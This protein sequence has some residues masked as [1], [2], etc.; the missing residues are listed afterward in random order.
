M[1]KDTGRVNIQDQSTSQNNS[2]IAICTSK[3]QV[4]TPSDS[5]DPAHFT[6]PKIPDID[7]DIGTFPE[8]DDDEFSKDITS[9]IH[10]FGVPLPSLTSTE[11]R[12]DVHGHQIPYNVP[13]APKVKKAVFVL[14][15][16]DE[17]VCPRSKLVK[18][19]E[20]ESITAE[21]QTRFRTSGQALA[22]ELE[23]HVRETKSVSKRGLFEVATVQESIHASYI[24]EKEEIMG[25]INVPKIE[26]ISPQS[27]VPPP[28]ETLRGNVEGQSSL[29]YKLSKEQVSEATAN[30]VHLS[31]D[32]KTQMDWP[33]SESPLSFTVESSNVL[34]WTEAESRRAELASE[35]R[36]SSPWFKVPKFTLKPHSTGFL[37]IT[38]EGSP[39][40]QR[41]GELGGDQDVPGSFCFHGTSTDP[42]CEEH[43]SSTI[44]TQHQDSTGEGTVTLL[45]KTT[46]VTHTTRTQTQFPEP[47]RAS[48]CTEPRQ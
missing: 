34:S 31:K 16:P 47:S 46:R 7:F 40:A 25:Q 44:S 4:P 39:Q 18:T 36:E 43:H 8:D 23:C 26:I 38:P 20:V 19:P 21:M 27:Q 1:P 41:R 14:V 42:L 12:F 32:K 3:T 37:Q 30:T 9:K 45:T 48:E 11:G 15:N 2:G 29:S 13:K 17:A 24:A 28:E 10:K 5:S 35:E 6:V 22:E 33:T